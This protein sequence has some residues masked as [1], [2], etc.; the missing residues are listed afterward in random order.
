M[1][2]TDPLGETKQALLGDA[3]PPVSEGEGEVTSVKAVCNSG[4]FLY[5]ALVSV[6]RDREF[7]FHCLHFLRRSWS[8]VLV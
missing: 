5:A 2:S 3:A 4:T 6:R 7:T 1:E 8:L